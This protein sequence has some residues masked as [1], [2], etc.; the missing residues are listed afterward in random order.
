MLD[1]YQ[2]EWMVV[3]GMELRYH[4]LRPVR[5]RMPVYSHWWFARSVALINELLK[6]DQYDPCA[7]G[8]DR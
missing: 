4:V 1:S 6:R 5:L 3:D 2:T 8:D 7:I